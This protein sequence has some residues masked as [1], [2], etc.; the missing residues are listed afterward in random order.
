MEQTVRSVRSD[1]IRY[2]RKIEQL[3]KINET[4]E[5]EKKWLLQQITEMSIKLN[6]LRA[7]NLYSK[8]E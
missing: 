8:K 3:E 4:L 5:M 6:E 1:N 7:K 2:R